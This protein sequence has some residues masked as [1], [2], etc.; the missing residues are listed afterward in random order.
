[1]KETEIN[2]NVDELLGAAA[3]TNADAYC[4]ET[5]QEAEEIIEM[6]ESSCKK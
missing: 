5:E 6:W 3:V 2:F 4:V 1:M